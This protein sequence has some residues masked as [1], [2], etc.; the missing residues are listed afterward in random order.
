MLTTNSADNTYNSLL[1][2]LSRGS[3][4][5]NKGHYPYT[6]FKAYFFQ[7]RLEKVEIS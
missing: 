6:D 2:K 3:D 5:F 7:P 1:D 4:K